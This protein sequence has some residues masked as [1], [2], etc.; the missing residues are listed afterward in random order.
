MTDED[1]YGGEDSTGYLFAAWWFQYVFAA[2]AATIVSGAMA[3]RTTLTGYA[4]YTTIITAFIYPTV[5]HWAWSSYGWVSPFNSGDGNCACEDCDI[6][7]DCPFRGG[8]MD[9]AGSGIVHMTGGM[10]ALMG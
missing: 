10:A 5:V 7:D 9:F 8:V 4:F 2:A 6:S 3:E 1:T